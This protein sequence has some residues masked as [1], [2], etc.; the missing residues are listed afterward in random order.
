[1]GQGFDRRPSDPKDNAG[2]YRTPPASPS[3]SG[4]APGPA[5]AEW[6]RDEKL[7]RYGLAVLLVAA[8]LAVLPLFRFFIV[9]VI[10][11]A[12]FCTLFYP[13]YSR[14]LTLFRGRSGLASLLTCF[15]LLGGLL[16]PAYALLHLVALQMVD[17]LIFFTTLGGIATFGVMGFIVGP[18]L[19][20]LFLA[21]VEIYKLEFKD[22]PGSAGM[23]G[24]PA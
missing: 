4:E 3:A 11:A 12:T 9:P 6:E 24:N 17:L 1:M 10:L 20:S 2:D 18:A 15:L 13:L 14:V 8:G 21:G 16:I 22:P 7:N 5:H 19:L 23:D